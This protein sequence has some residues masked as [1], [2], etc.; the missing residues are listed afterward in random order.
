[1]ELKI[2]PPR[3]WRF[4]LTSVLLILTAAAVAASAGVL[5]GSGRELDHWE[6]LTRFITRFIPPD[7][8]VLPEI[9]TGI[10]ETARIAVIATVLAVCISMPL[11]ALAA[12]RLSPPWLA[13]PARLL[14]NV[15]RTVPALVWA[16]FGVALVGANTL[17]GVIALTFY[18]VGYL[19]KLF[20]DACD[21]V[22]PGAWRA[23]RQLGADPVQAALHGFWPEIRPHLWSH[24]LWMAE[25]NL[26]SASIIGYVGAGGLGVLLH[27][28]QEYG[29]WDRVA[30]VLL[31]L[32][33]V[34]VVLDVL[35]D[36]VRGKLT[37]LNKSE[38]RSR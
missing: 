23:L 13:W 32:L 38:K 5:R 22:D 31:C 21:S 16:L 9:G 37:G 17:A 30:T 11:A 25:Y 29:R 4:E 15:I 14:L 33:V 1:M 28:Y 35:G 18:S 36:R 3:W 19:G 8:S 34:V 7:L 20:A 26:R 10:I 12:R 24:S 27:T 6:N 2:P